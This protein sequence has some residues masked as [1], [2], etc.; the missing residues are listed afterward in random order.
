MK[1][2]FDEINA[3]VEK[4]NNLEIPLTQSVN[5]LLSNL[6]KEM[7]KHRKVPALFLYVKI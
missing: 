1:L 6:K 7:I 2:S 3:I 4:V 5:D